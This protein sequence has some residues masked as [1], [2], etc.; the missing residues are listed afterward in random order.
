MSSSSSTD[1]PLL[2]PE[3]PFMVTNIE[4]KGRGAVATRDIGAGEVVL[5]SIPFSMTPAEPEEDDEVVP[6]CG[7]CLA[8]RNDNGPELSCDH[9][10]L[11]QYCSEGCK[12]AHQR[13]QHTPEVCKGYTHG[14]QIENLKEMFYYL[15]NCHYMKSGNAS[16]PFNVCPGPEAFNQ[17]MKQCDEASV[18]EEEIMMAFTNITSFYLGLFKDDPNCLSRETC[19]SLLVKDLQNS[20]IA[21]EGQVSCQSPPF[22]MFNHNC[23]PNCARITYDLNQEGLGNLPPCVII[24]RS[25]Q[26]IPSGQELCISYTPVGYR[27]SDRREHLEE[28]YGIE[29]DC[30][31]CQLEDAM[32]AE[33]EGRS[34]PSSHHSD[35]ELDDGC[36]K[37]GYYHVFM[38]RF[39][40]TQPDC[41]GTFVPFRYDLTT[42]TRTVFGSQS[43]ELHTNMECNTCYHLRSEDEFD[44]EMQNQN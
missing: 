31:R 7:R 18:V 2:P 10:G 15:I 30:N 38:T 16:A 28:S 39:S 26:P 20:C 40:C 41:R 23:Y 35:E 33:E 44:I 9:C 8:R 32:E 24:V 34:V 43:G 11:F 12:A 37:E 21:R 22:S 42:G 14:S 36:T 5:A 27:A 29:C 17:I 13:E 3:C 1:A 19:M 6:F 25:I 4:G